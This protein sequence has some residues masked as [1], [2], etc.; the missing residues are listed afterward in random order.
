MLGQLDRY[1]YTGVIKLSEFDFV[2][3]KLTF[4]EYQG[5]LQGYSLKDVGG[6]RETRSN[7][8]GFYDSASK[9]FRF[10][11]YDVIYTKASSRTEDICL[12]RFKSSMKEL[13]TNKVFSNN[14]KMYN[15]KG[16]ACMEGLII[17]SRVFNKASTVIASQK[18]IN[19][20]VKTKTTPIKKEV[21]THVI[22]T[23]TY[24]VIKKNENLN[25]FIKTKEITI[26]IYDSGK[27]DDDR[28][29]LYI[30]DILFLEDYAIEKEKKTIPLTITNETTVLRVEALTEGTSAPNTVKVEIQDGLNI[31]STRTSLKTGEKA[32]LTL[33]KQ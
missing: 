24:S 7:I 12:V 18:A 27:V 9:T 21:A 16:Q 31:I 17:M 22:D 26:S 25:V 30:D 5:N 14:F 1:E 19:P 32:S 4:E 8:K 29:N 23:L 15:V 20:T 33:V 13:K 28:I 10:S 11:E 3:Y 6:S 2:P